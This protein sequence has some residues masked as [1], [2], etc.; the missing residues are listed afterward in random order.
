MAVVAGEI[1]PQA[2][3]ELKG[4]QGPPHEWSPARIF[5][6][7][8]EVL[9]HFGLPC[10]DGGRGDVGPHWDDSRLCTDWPSRQCGR[11]SGGLMAIARSNTGGRE[12]RL[13]T[14]GSRS[15]GGWAGIEPGDLRALRAS[16]DSA[17]PR[18][19]AREFSHRE[20]TRSLNWRCSRGPKTFMRICP[21]GNSGDDSLRPWGSRKRFAMVFAGPQASGA[22][23]GAAARADSKKSLRMSSPGRCWTLSG[24]SR[25]IRE[26]IRVGHGRATAEIPRLL[27]VPPPDIPV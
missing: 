2:D 8:I 23:S 7:P 16:G 11:R 6:M 18:S 13:R 4:S 5:E 3:V 9:R 10:A 26:S 1:A 15:K 24:Q 27:R 19:T 22:P 17:M 25:L 14:D 12:A 20:E 21:V